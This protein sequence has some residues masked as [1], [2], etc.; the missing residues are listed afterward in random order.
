ML[1]NLSKLGCDGSWLVSHQVLKST[2]GNVLSKKARNIVSVALL[3]ELD[4]DWGWFIGDQILESAA[5]DIL[6]EEA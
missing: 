1:G 3:G 6:T 2:T 4:G 5:S